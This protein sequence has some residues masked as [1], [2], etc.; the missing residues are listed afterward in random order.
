[1]ADKRD[2]GLYR[3]S[4]AIPVENKVKLDALI[5][6]LKLDS[7]ADLLNMLAA[8]FHEAAGALDDFAAAYVKLKQEKRD[9]ERKIKE[10]Q[11]LRAKLEA[12][13]NPK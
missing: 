4:F 2:D 6:R 3:S 7:M 12:L 1:M 8:N 11:R 5:S 9:L 10:Q 13:E